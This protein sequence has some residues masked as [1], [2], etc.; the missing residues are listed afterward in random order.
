[1][2]GVALL[3][4]LVVGA[5]TAAP[6]SAVFP[7]VNGR[8]V[9]GGQLYD[10][11]NATALSYPWGSISSVRFSADDT[12]VVGVEGMLSPPSSVWIA[13]IDGSNAR[14]LTT[15]PYASG[16]GDLQPTWS[17]DG[18]EVAF[19]REGQP[20]PCPPPVEGNC[21]ASQLLVVD[22]ATGQTTSLIDAQTGFFVE[23][24]DWSPDPD[25]HQVVVTLEPYE[26][27]TDEVDLVDTNTG[28][29]TTLVSGAYDYAR[30]SPDGQ[31][32]VAATENFENGNPTLSVVPLAGGTALS[33]TV[34]T[35]SEGVTYPTFTPD[36][37]AVTMS[38]CQPGCGIWNA[39]L[40]PA[41]AP[42]GTPP[43]FQEVLAQS[44]FTPWLLD[45]E[46]LID[47]P[48][49]TA[50]PVGSVGTADATFEFSI[51]STE[52][53]TYQCQID[54]QGWQDGCASPRTYT[55]LP[56]G[57]HTFQVRFYVPGQDPSQAP[58]A[59]RSWTVDTTAPEALIEQAPSGSTDA[60]DATIDF[61][62]TEPDGATY[63]CS[64]DG[65]AEYDCSSPQVLT[66]LDVGTHTFGVKATDDVGNEQQSPTT[67]SWEVVEP[68]G[69]PGSG[70]GAGGGA[71]GGG[72][73]S[74]GAPGGGGASGGAPGGGGASGGAPGGGGASGGA[75]GGGGAGGTTPPQAPTSGCPSGRSQVTAGSVIAVARGT[76]CF[77]RTAQA[78][79]SVNWSAAGTISLNGVELTSPSAMVLH[80]QATSMTIELPAGTTLGFGSFTWTLPSSISLPVSTAA[81]AAHFL[82]PLFGKALKVAGLPVAAKPDFQLST[83]DGGTAKVTLELELPPAFQG[84]AGDQT[85][86]EKQLSVTFHFEFS[87]SNDKGVRFA[88]TTT[89]KNLWLFGGAVEVPSLSLGLDTGP[90]LSFDGIA[91]MKF[92][93][94]DGTFTLEVGLSG[95]GEQAFP[96]VTKLALQASKLNKPIAE[97]VFLQRLGGEFVRCV[98]NDGESGGS[99]SA[100]AGMSIGPDLDLEPI[101]KGPPVELD[102]GVTL[103]LCQ[104]KSIEISGVGSV[105][106][107]P[108]AD[109]SVKYTWSTGKIDLAGNVNLTLGPLVVAAG[110][111]D[112]FFDTAGGTWQ[113]EA[114]GKLKLPQFAGV[115][116]NGQ[117]DIVFS[118]SGVAACFGPPGARYGVAQH[119]NQPV[120]S[121]D[122]DCD[123]GPYRAAGATSARVS[124]VGQF[125]I[126]GHERIALIELHG[127]TAPPEASLRGP[128]GERI[129]MPING[130]GLQSSRAVVL[131][132]PKTDTSY[133][134][135]FSPA[136][137][138]W[139][140]VPEQSGPPP[141]VRVAD[142]VPPVEVSARVSG[143][144][145]RRL[146]S[147][148]LRPLPGQRVTFV[149]LGAGTVHTL[150]STDLAHGRLT[151]RPAG[152]AGRARRIEA[153]VDENGLPRDQ[154]VVGRFTAPLA[155]KLGAVKKLRL[156]GS[157]LRW[158]PEV[159]AVEY[160]L[161]LRSTGGATFS[162][163]TSH[164]SLRVPASMRHQPLA[165]SISALGANSVAGP[166]RTT[167]VR[168]KAR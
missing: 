7:G 20:I 114:T 44:S 168:P 127:G 2:V 163:V 69:A 110:I 105:V 43:S 144:G 17:P 39:V 121:F 25:S 91:T 45:W 12:R 96:L 157:L 30:F 63:V 141:S 27:N 152:G 162:S 102:G 158:S 8:L 73:A 131:A 106:G 62:S 34:T 9:V 133:V 95:E 82:L 149:E 28:A 42:P 46:P 77:V 80:E 67:V 129:D 126:P 124:A 71:P 81:T 84:A 38:A 111:T 161:L 167:V 83:A 135:L 56:D 60:T 164:P 26:A 93:G 107:V 103:Y 101:F 19:V 11:P 66:A 41:D 57:Q 64:V 155:P 153:L 166:P 74:G 6:A 61:T 136:A 79:G 4:A 132:D 145:A 143:R 128:G 97:G 159:G 118:S 130:G 142:G 150:A 10:P 75:P 49:I 47:E 112:S 115:A 148:S 40:P 59:S 68:S 35:G 31:S 116:L 94:V 29:R 88:F 54:Q 98:G 134:I 23:E 53:G 120:K 140:V 24:P 76:T 14:Q 154:L 37:Q 15:Y 32:V 16:D 86:S 33:F 48:A 3:L 89:V 50:G 21:P 156:S 92:E 165:V 117:G 109:A 72:G 123:V 87:A 113:V 22:V 36:G 70:G 13:D 18:K 125:S 58:A 137:G 122:G 139:T 5:S 55:G 78:D 1:L 108:L 146:L 51:P 160:S 90:P 52:T 104:P 119:W 138:D 147:W 65:G 99:L 151:F 85:S 100:N